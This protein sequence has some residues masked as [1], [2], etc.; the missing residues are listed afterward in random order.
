MGYNTQIY[1]DVKVKKEKISVFME[2]VDSL[3][4]RV[5]LLDFIGLVILLI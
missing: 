3:K 4:L 2:E 5:K 1:G